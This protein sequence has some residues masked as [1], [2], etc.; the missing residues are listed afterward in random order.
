MFDPWF[1]PPVAIYNFS[2][3]LYVHVINAVTFPLPP[4]LPSTSFSAEPVHAR[5]HRL[6]LHGPFAPTAVF[7]SENDDAGPRAIHRQKVTRLLPSAVLHR[8]LQLLADGLSHVLHRCHLLPLLRVHRR[9]TRS[10]V[11]K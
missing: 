1:K 4:H 9:N 11:A 8:L 2:I 7:Q 6:H 3:R 10:H 5:P